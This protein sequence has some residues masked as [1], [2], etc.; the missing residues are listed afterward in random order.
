MPAASGQVPSQGTSRSTSA[1]IPPNILRYLAPIAAEDGVDLRPALTRVGLDEAV[2]RSAALRVSYRQ[3]SAV[4]RRAIELTADA[5]LGLRVGAAQHL[6][7]W[8]LLGFA[9]M[10]ADT[11]R[12]AVETGM[13]FQNLSGA[14]VVWS[15]RQE[16][17]GFVLRVDLPDP[18]LDP[19]VAVFLVEEAF[20]SVTTLTR[21]T[22]GPAFAPQVVE[23][24]FPTPRDTGLFDDLFRC[25]VRFGAAGNRLVFP[26]SWAGTAMPGRDPVTFAS[27]LELLDAQVVSRRSRQ[28][29]LEVVEVSI[30]QSLPTVPSFA[31]QAHRHAAGERT[32]RRRPAECGT[33]YEAI[34][35]G[36]RRE[37]VEQLLRR[38]EL[39]L[40][41][42]ARRVGF[43]DVRALR[44]AVR[45]W[46][47]VAPLQL[48]GD[49]LDREGP[50]G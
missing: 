4:I 33:T 38:P 16:D 30:A 23:F 43:S 17:L 49:I 9:L 3:G 12:D 18:A 44:R 29:L 26:D 10:A 5:H 8:G 20:S 2:M 47:G 35:D 31:Q 11:L 45:R 13:R 39:T 32:L 22:M 40:S 21:L 14:M 15:A 19:A 46:H 1:T 50:V 48:R 24:A 25:P 36:V 28:D 27:V 7:S 34:V 42:I 37:R 6:T 41:D